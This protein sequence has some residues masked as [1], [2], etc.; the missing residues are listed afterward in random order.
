[1]SEWHDEVE[2]KKMPDKIIYLFLIF[3]F[4]VKERKKKDENV[5]SVGMK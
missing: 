2:K 4:Q 1:M 3:F 5:R